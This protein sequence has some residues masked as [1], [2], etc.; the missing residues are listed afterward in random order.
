MKLESYKDLVVWQK[1]VKLTTEVYATTEKY[2]PKETYGL[3]YQTRKSAVSIPSNIAE[4]WTR[5]HRQEYIH[6]LSI[7]LGSAAE[8]ETQIIIGNK[9]GFLADENFKRLNELNTEIMKMINSLIAALKS[10]SRNTPP[11]P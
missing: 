11:N 3:T 7:A 9:L 6:S 1:A 10:K 8:L 5:K 2:P 4:G